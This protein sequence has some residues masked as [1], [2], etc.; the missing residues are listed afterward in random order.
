MDVAEIE[1]VMAISKAASRASAVAVAV[2]LAVEGWRL[3]QRSIN[4]LV[5]SD[6]KGTQSTGYI[7]LIS[8][9]RAPNGVIPTVELSVPIVI[10][11]I[12][13]GSRQHKFQQSLVSEL[14]TDVLL[15]NEQVVWMYALPANMRMTRSH[16]TQKWWVGEQA[17][18]K[19]PEVV[20]TVP[21]R[22]PP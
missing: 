17:G 7:A 6:S 15:N 11:F 20:G 18:K 2:A 9:S 10:S 4:L 8:V 22:R 14:M 5:C 3:L 16:D 21:K 13:L 12:N 1:E 19:W